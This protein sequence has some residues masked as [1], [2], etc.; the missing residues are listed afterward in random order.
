MT[1]P[2]NQTQASQPRGGQ[3]NHYINV[4]LN[5]INNILEVAAQG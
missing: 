4:L 1:R 5:K 2:G 3:S